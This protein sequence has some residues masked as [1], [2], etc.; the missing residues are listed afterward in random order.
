MTELT[1]EKSVTERL[2]GLLRRPISDADRHRA[3][4]HLVDWIGCAVISRT[5]P[6]GIAIESEATASSTGTAQLF[7]AR[8]ADPATAAFVLGGF[9]SVLEMDDVHRAALLHPG[10]VVIPAALAAAS[11]TTPA[12][13]FLDAMIRG[14]EAMIRLG[15]ATGPGHYAY[16]HNTATCGG[17]GSAAASASLL[18][19]DDTEFVAAFGNAGSVSGG[20]WQCRNEPVMTKTL[21]VAE[22]ARRGLVAACLAARGFTGPRFILEGPQGFFAAICPGASAQDVVSDADAGWL[23]GETSF[24]PWP[25]CRHAHAAIDAALALRETIAG[26]PIAAI[27]I[28]T[29]ADAKLFCDRPRPETTL[30]AKFSLQHA[31]AVALQDGGPPLDA[32]DIP[33]LGRPELVA[34][35][36]ISTVAAT[37]AF[38]TP[39]P[40][41]FGSAVT[42]TL[43]TGETLS[44]SVSDAWGDSENPISD[45]AL[46]AKARALMAA[47]GL[48]ADRADALVDAA[49]GLAAGGTLAPLRLAMAQ[50]ST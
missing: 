48:A 22:A 35:R 43:T 17:F 8:T 41:H 44:R 38:T 5:T 33:A 49:L 42:I 34:L 10:P 11:D 14:Y 12:G 6:T 25:A 21:H 50:A 16:F 18:A 40:R 31:V 13:D 32:F 37:E 19:L 4:R 29:Y 24:K 23:I 47:A 46:F 26:R 28:D 36:E 3:A 1:D 45:D 20:L 30:Q 9:G 7:G 39:Y 27:A 2:V 15:R